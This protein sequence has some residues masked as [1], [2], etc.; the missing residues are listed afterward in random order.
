MGRV[1]SVDHL[2]AGPSIAARMVD[3]IVVTTSSWPCELRRQFGV[4]SLSIAS[5]AVWSAPWLGQLDAVGH[6]LWPRPVGSPR[7]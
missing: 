1:L 3:P 5:R 7:W 6:P 2:V 4:L